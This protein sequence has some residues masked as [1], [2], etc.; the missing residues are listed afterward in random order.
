MMIQP[1]QCY[2]SNI[3]PQLYVRLASFQHQLQ[4]GLRGGLSLSFIAELLCKALCL[5]PG[6]V[7]PRTGAQW[8]RVIPPEQRRRR[9]QPF[10]GCLASFG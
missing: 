4:I 5:D 3:M 2:S 8:Q 7:T 1:L 9:V 10:C 6:L